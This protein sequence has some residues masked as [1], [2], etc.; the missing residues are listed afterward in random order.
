MIF[1]RANNANVYLNLTSMIRKFVTLS[2]RKY[3][4]WQPAKL[5]WAMFLLQSGSAQRVLNW[6]LNFSWIPW[7]L[8]FRYTLFHERTHFL[9]S[10][11]SA[12]YQIWLKSATTIWVPTT[13]MSSDH[14]NQVI[15]ASFSLF[16]MQNSDITTFCAD[17][18]HTT[19]VIF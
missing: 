16:T 2:E 1:N 8:S 3:E 18:F 13:I 7:N 4:N 17:V 9:V 5:H 19:G 12:F 11:G 15:H 10:P 14:F 6:Q